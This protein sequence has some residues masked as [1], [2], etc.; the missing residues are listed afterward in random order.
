[1]EEYDS[2]NL[3]SCYSDEFSSTSVSCATLSPFSCD[4]MELTEMQDTNSLS[5]SKS[6]YDK[7]PICQVSVSEFREHYEE[8]TNRVDEDS[9]DSIDNDELHDFDHLLPL[10]GN[11][12]T[13]IKAA[14]VH[15]WQIT[16]GVSDAALDRFL[17][18]LNCFPNHLNLPNS[19][20]V[21]KTRVRHIFRDVP[22]VIDLSLDSGESIKVLDLKHQINI[23]LSEYS[24][25][26]REYHQKLASIRYTDILNT[27][28][29]R[30]KIWECSLQYLD[31]YFLCSTDGGS[32]TDT[33]L[34]IWP[35][36]LQILNMPVLLRQM[37]ENMILL[38]LISSSFKPDL[39]KCL[40]IILE[41]VPRC[42]E[43]V[44]GQIIRVHIDFFVGDLPA[45]SSV[46]QIKQFNGR[47]SC[48]K[49]LHPGE[50]SHSYRNWVFRQT[51]FQIPLRTDE[52][53]AQHVAASSLSQK[54]VFGVKGA[55]S[56]ADHVS[57]PSGYIIDVMHCLYEGQIKFILE[58]FRNLKLRHLPCVLNVH[59]LKEINTTLKKVKIPVDVRVSKKQIS[60]LSSWKAKET[61]FF[62]LHLLLPLILTVSSNIDMKHLLISLILFYHLSYSCR[63]DVDA[64]KKLTTYFLDNALTVFPESLLRLNF[65]LLCHLPEQYKRFGPFNVAS[66]FPFEASMK[67]YKSFI[68]GSNSQANQIAVK[69]TQLKSLL[70][71]LRSCKDQNVEKALARVDLRYQKVTSDSHVDSEH[72]AIWKGKA[73]RSKS[74]DENLLSSSCYVYLNS[75]E[76]GCIE[77]FQQPDT[78]AVKLIKVTG[79][80]L[81]NRYG[82]IDR[83]PELQNLVISCMNSCE[84]FRFDIIEQ[85][86][87]DTSITTTLSNIKYRC[88]IIPLRACTCIVPLLEV[89]EH[90]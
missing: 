3:S 81:V 32:F 25:A 86:D 1:M 73:L 70:H 12:N 4:E 31:L 55:S 90:D 17:K 35:V 83:N 66:M 53:H 78:L 20:D 34:S 88:V 67:L 63:S 33:N 54:S 42:F 15:C 2:D 56:I 80:N 45:M 72:R 13:A 65:H 36:Q 27:D 21:L 8:R 68:C 71:F 28:L 39:K 6:E 62:S 52:T 75:C 59:Q 26:I 74:Y 50:M 57:F 69:F 14:L 87:T 10:L 77:K 79:Q 38:G 60:E 85:L 46:F 84:S 16:S 23:V 49:C 76:Y 82:E 11:T 58:C 51:D 44:R 43:T 18:M 61:R 30:G 64:M 29:M 22:D 40:P 41:H 24:D 37:K 89:D 5:N 7:S 19:V 47:F 9:C 48:P